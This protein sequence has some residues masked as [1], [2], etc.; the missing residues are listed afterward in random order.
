MQ[1]QAAQNR[2]ENG[3][4]PTETEIRKLSSRK[5]RQKRPIWH[6]PGILRFAE[7]G[8]WR[9]SG[10]NWR[11]AT[12]SS[13]AEP[14]TEICDA[15]TGTLKPAYHLAEINPETRS[16]R[17]PAPRHRHRAAP[18]RAGR[19]GRAIQGARTQS[20][21]TA[22][23]HDIPNYD[24]TKESRLGAQARS[25]YALKP[26]GIVGNRVSR[27]LS[28]NPSPRSG[29]SPLFTRS[30]GDRHAIWRFCAEKRGSH[31]GT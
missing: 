2:H 6:R 11:P 10:T 28:S 23:P 16:G 26:I 4:A 20:G 31:P 14:G 7:T 8:W 15:E 3:C 21:I 22:A 13:N 19:V 9:H 25:L 29:L 17:S 24:G 12:Q 30:I 27:R 5:S 1:R 18:R